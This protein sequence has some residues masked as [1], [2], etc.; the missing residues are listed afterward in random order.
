MTHSPGL[1]RETKGHLPCLT[2]KG[3]LAECEQG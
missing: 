2:G 3:E 1:G